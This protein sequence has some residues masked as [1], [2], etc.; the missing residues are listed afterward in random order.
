MS[1]A[2]QPYRYPHPLTLAR[3]RADAERDRSAHVGESVAASAWGQ[4]GGLTTFYRH[5]S[6]HYRRMALKRWGE[7][8]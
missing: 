5:G 7:R 8:P 1:A 2:E 3:R 4:L 6:E